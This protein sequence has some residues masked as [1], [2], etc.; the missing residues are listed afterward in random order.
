MFVQLFF[1]IVVVIM[2]IV[3]SAEAVNAVVFAIKG[4]KNRFIDEKED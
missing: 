4:H 3:L 2:G 1:K